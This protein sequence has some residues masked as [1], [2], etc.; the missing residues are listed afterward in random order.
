METRKGERGK[1]RPRSTSLQHLRKG[2]SVC[3]VDVDNNRGLTRT[4]SVPEKAFRSTFDIFI[5]QA[6]ARDCL[7]PGE[8]STVL[9]GQDSV[10]HLPERFAIIPASRS[11][12]SLDQILS[13][14]PKIR[15]EKHFVRALGERS[16]ACLS[17]LLSKLVLSWSGGNL[18]ALFRN[19]RSTAERRNSPT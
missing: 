12:E 15:P 16:C 11:L 18:D 4:L 13:K 7:L 3:L 14:Q 19:D 8:F 1:P 10:V 2:R 5:G 17:M 6:N 9:N